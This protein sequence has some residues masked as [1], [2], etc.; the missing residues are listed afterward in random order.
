MM[1][2]LVLTL[3]LEAIDWRPSK[4]NWRGC[5]RAG[6]WTASDRDIQPQPCTPRT[7]NDAICLNLAGNNFILPPLMPEVCARMEGLEIRGFCRQAAETRVKNLEAELRE[8]EAAFEETLQQQV[9]NAR[10]SSDARY[11]THRQIC[12]KFGPSPSAGSA[13]SSREPHHLQRSK[14]PCTVERLISIGLGLQWS[15]R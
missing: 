8:R 2:L 7:D 6:D 13:S 5:T 11:R 1:S 15:I 4:K 3:H 9:E 12:H 14:M 10:S